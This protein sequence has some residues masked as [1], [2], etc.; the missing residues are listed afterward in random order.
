MKINEIGELAGVGGE[1]EMRGWG[2]SIGSS[3]GCLATTVV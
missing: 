1:V 2:C 3:G